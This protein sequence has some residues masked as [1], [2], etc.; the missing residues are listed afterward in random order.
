[1]LA[2]FL[3][4]PL[5]GGL[6]RRFRDVLLGYKHSSGNTTD[7]SRNDKDSTGLTEANSWSLVVGKKTT[8][9]F[10]TGNRKTKTNMDRVYKVHNFVN[11]P[12]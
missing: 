6:F 8:R 1:M 4:K 2:D 7:G 5:Q 10:P 3:T 12:S 11:N 9:M